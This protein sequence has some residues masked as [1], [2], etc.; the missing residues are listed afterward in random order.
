[1]FILIAKLLVEILPQVFFGLEHL[2]YI[3]AGGI[4]GESERY[5]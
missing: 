2:R 3:C 5:V 4:Y 1:M